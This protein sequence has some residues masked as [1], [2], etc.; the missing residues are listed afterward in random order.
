MDLASHALTC[1]QACQSFSN[2]SRHPTCTAPLCFAPRRSSPEEAFSVLYF[3]FKEFSICPHLLCV[4]LLL[5]QLLHLVALRNVDCQ[6]AVIVHRRHIAP[7]VKQEP[8]DGEKS[9]RGSGMK[10]SPAFVVSSIDVSSVG[11]QKL[12]HVEIV[13]NAR[14]EGMDIEQ[15]NLLHWRTFNFAHI[16]L[17]GGFELWSSKFHVTFPIFMLKVSVSR[18]QFSRSAF[19]QQ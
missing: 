13:V 7:V 2:P 4:D 19:Q 8:G 16:E 17:L 3:C 15:C 14:L 18:Y 11:H 9:T 5:Q 10:R 6:L 1:L 12:H